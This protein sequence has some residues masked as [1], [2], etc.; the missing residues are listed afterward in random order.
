MQAS[1]RV[2]VI[3][4]GSNTFHLLIVQQDNSA[5]GFHEI[6]RKRIYVYLSKNGIDHILPTPYKNGLDCLAKF[7]QE[8]N[9]HKVYKYKCIGTSALRSANN[10]LHFIK[11]AKVLHEI[12]IDVIDGHREADLIFKGISLTGLPDV[13][14]LTLDIGGG[15]LELILAK[16]NEV[17]S[18]TSVNIGI[19]VLRNLRKKEDPISRSEIEKLE[20]VISRSLSEYLDSLSSYK[21]IYL[22]GAA[23]AF[24]IIEQMIGMKSSISG[25]IL[26]KQ[27]CHRKE[28]I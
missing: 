18:S 24:E 10:G 9:F 25:N 11:D 19:S 12:D 23:G 20:K 14:T 16:K 22:V 5:V 8:I 27:K 2:A 6:F 3:D 17:I 21:P 7:R 26:E 15:S 28:L 4:C 13:E 1:N